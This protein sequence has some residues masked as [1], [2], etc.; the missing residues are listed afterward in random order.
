M[1]KCA[2]ISNVN[3][4]ILFLCPSLIHQSSIMDLF[5]EGPI[6]TLSWKKT[7]R[8][9]SRNDP[10]LLPAVP[11]WIAERIAASFALLS[12]LFFD[13]CI[14]QHYCS[15]NYTGGKL[16]LGL[17]VAICSHLN[18]GVS[19]WWKRKFHT[20]M[21]VMCGNR[22]CWMRFDTDLKWK[23]YV[24]VYAYAFSRCFFFNCQLQKPQFSRLG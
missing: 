6:R 2:S 14:Q 17:S 5:S 9:Q 13:L 24:Y 23:H 16:L 21:G 4:Q 7:M 15:P 12:L 20:W 18:G 10:W 8:N 3:T 19:E 11:T 1:R 22:S